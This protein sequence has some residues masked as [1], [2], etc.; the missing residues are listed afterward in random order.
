M[1]REVLTLVVAVLVVGGLGVGYYFYQPPGHPSTGVSQTTYTASNPNLGIRLTI[2][3]NA[4]AI[5]VGGA[6]NYSASVYNTRPSEN[7]VSSASNWA[8]PGLIYTATGATDSPIAY[9]VMPGYYVSNN[10]SKA[11]S[12][13][14]GMCCTTVM[15]GVTMYSFQPTSDIASVYASVAHCNSNPCFTRPVST[16][17][18]LS[19]YQ[20]GVGGGVHWV[21]FTA[22]VYTVVAED[23]WGDFALASF[24]VA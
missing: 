18:L 9:A 11:P 21:S 15:G 22:G 13:D 17:R 2:W 10:I 4:S 5:H 20:I 19:Q 24:T 23:E 6:V 3:L 16:W 14:Y 12:I 7:N 1:K 8:I